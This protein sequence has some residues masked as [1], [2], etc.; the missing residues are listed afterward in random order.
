MTAQPLTF[1]DRLRV[2]AD[3]CGDVQAVEC[4]NNNL[5]IQEYRL[6]TWRVQMCRD[7]DPIPRAIVRPRKTAEEPSATAEG[8]DLYAEFV[9]FGEIEDARRT[10]RSDNGAGRIE[11]AAAVAVLRQSDDAGDRWIASE[12]A[13]G[14]ELSDREIRRI[15]RRH[16]ENQGRSLVSRGRAAGWK[17]IGICGA[18]ALAVAALLRS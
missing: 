2:A 17:A 10:I 8:P 5:R 9:A 15:A 14:L 16:K 6:T 7:Q 13:A 4:P 18:A 3:T 1:A 11:I 12:I